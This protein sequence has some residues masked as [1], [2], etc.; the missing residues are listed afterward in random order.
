MTSRGLVAL[1]ALVFAAG[2]AG[3]SK[4]EVGSTGGSSGS[5]GSAG[6]GGG[7]S[8][9]IP[10]CAVD[11]RSDPAHCGRCF[12]SCEGGDC[13]AGMCQPVRLVATGDKAP[14]ALAVDHEHV[15]WA[16]PISR[17][18]KDYGNF[19][20]SMEGTAGD[21]WSIAVD[22]RHAYWTNVSGGLQRVSLDG[23]ARDVVG[24]P[25]YRVAL[26]D[27]FVYFTSSTAVARMPKA[28]EERQV[29]AEMPSEAL[30][31]DDTFVYFTVPSGGGLFRVAK[32]GGEPEALTKNSSAS[33]I[34][35]WDGAVF[36]SEQATP[37]GV[38]HVTGPGLRTLVAPVE[39]PY[40][41]AVDGFGVFWADWLDGSIWV[42]SH[43][44]GAEPV[45][46]A[47]GQ[48]YPRN[49][50]VDARAVYFTNDDVERSVMKVAKP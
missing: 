42:R 1:L 32:E 15:W 20:S 40:G 7:G 8:T 48:P 28:L 45:K 37:S 35:A 41:V 25:G 50:A 19:P 34:A 21:V 24:A 27:D 4:L 29:L 2:C 38:F 16:S 18:G 49:V 31:V 39:E 30:D 22:D 9:G 44:P 6:A 13:V 3:R 17:A 23:A 12:H 10:T 11:V 5:G 26:D 43:E 14:T 36:V 33:Y 46:L 47:S